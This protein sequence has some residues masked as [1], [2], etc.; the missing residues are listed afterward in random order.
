MKET[1]KL[2]RVEIR[3]TDEDRHTSSP[4]VAIYGSKSGATS[5]VNAALR[6]G[7]EVVSVQELKADWKPSR[8][9]RIPLDHMFRQ[10]DE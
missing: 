10:L 3:K 2:Y 1:D 8:D 9:V 4:E 5:K 7:W 6:M